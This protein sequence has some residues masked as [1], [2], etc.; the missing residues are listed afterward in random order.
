VFCFQFKLAPL[1]PQRLKAN[2]GKLLSCF[3]FN[4]NL[5]PCAKDQI[6]SL[7]NKLTQRAEVRESFNFT[8]HP[9]PVFSDFL[10]DATRADSLEGLALEVPPAAYCS[11]RHRMPFNSIHEGS[12]MRVDDA[13]GDIY[14][15]LAEGH[16]GEPQLRRVL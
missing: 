5:R 6:K 10:K 16:H 14:L 7:F 13:A 8:R 15:A 11:P 3:A 1:H 4:F 2:Y 9:D 12:K